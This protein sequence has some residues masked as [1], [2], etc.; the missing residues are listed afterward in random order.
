MIFDYPLRAT[1]AEILDDL[2]IDQVSLK[3]NLKEIEKVNHSL[4]AYSFLRKSLLQLFKK[5][6]GTNWKLSDLGC[7]GGDALRALYKDPSLRD[8]ISCWQGLDYN[9][10]VLDF[11]KESSKS[12]PFEFRQVNLLDSSEDYQ[13][14]IGMFN[15]VLHHFSDDDIESL[16]LRASKQCR[17]ILISD[18]HRNAIAYHSFRGLSHFWR[19]NEVSRHDGKLSV[20]KSF[21]RRDWERILSAVPHREVQIQWHWS[22]RWNLILKL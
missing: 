19:F 2:N 6:G 9:P 15:L 7:G 8:H 18:L 20:Q 17:F 14:D 13:A 16:L 21:I 4:G 12:L 1:K 5:E 11:A 3:Q 22:F 10:S